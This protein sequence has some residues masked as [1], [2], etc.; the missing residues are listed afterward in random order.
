MPFDSTPRTVYSFVPSLF[1]KFSCNQKPLAVLLS[2]LL[3]GTFA[4]SGCSNSDS[5]SSP[6]TVVVDSTVPSIMQA[7]QTAQGSVALS[8]TSP[9]LTAVDATDSRVISI[10]D[11]SNCS[12]LL[13]IVPTSITLVV[14]GDAEVFN[15]T[16]PAGNCQ[17]IITFSGSGV[18]SSSNTSDINVIT[19]Q[20]VVTVGLYDTNGDETASVSQ[21]GTIKIKF[22]PPVNWEGVTTAQSYTVS[23]STSGITFANNPC[24]LTPPATTVCQVT[25]SIGESVTAANHSFS[26]ALGSSTDVPVDES[27]LTFTV[28]SLGLFTYSGD[29]VTD[30]AITLT[31]G[32]DA[33]M[34]TLSNTGETAITSLTLNNEDGD[35]DNFTVT[36]PDNG[37]CDA[38]TDSTLPAEDS[39]TFSLAVDAGVDAGD[40]TFATTGTSVSNSPTSLTVDAISAARFV[41]GTG[42]ASE[43]MI[44]TVTNLMW[45]KEGMS[46]TQVWAAAETD[47]TGAKSGNLCGFNNWTNPSMLQLAGENPNNTDTTTGLITGLITGWDTEKICGDGTETCDSP[48]SWL[49]AQGFGN[50][51]TVSN[52]QPWGVYWSGTEVVGNPGVAWA[53]CLA[54]SCV[55]GG[56]GPGDVITVDNF[57]S[58]GVLPV[59]QQ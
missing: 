50:F 8:S 42:T 33:S 28:N 10:S 11:T 46:A 24:T 25:A 20:A 39:C 27:S 45:A 55:G 13:S 38:L 43:C 36:Y 48:V 34:I 47:P 22:T 59:R 9:S 26:I 32:G 52:T 17:H 54:A 15:I 53:V 14:D 6:S 16:A 31:I 18:S 41:S 2:S 49:Q 5:S 35:S 21:G 12:V 44:D 3:C 37:G 4:L 23:T 58:L 29:D 7:G 40:Y 57:N 19:D 1:R 51:Y 30:N 56:V